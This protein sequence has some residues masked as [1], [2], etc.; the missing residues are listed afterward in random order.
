MYPVTNDVK[1]LF[2][3]EQPQVLRITGV[4]KNGAQILITDANALMGS[5]YIDRFSS[6]N[7]RIEV[8]TA[9]SAEMGVK[10]NNVD[11]TYDNIVFEGAEL[12]VEIGVKDNGSIE[13]QDWTTGDGDTIVT[14]HGQTVGF[15][16]EGT[17]KWVPCGYFICDVQPR[18]Q[19]IITLSALDRMMYFDKGAGDNALV[20]PCTV[21]SLVQQCCVICNVPLV[22]D[23]TVLPNASYNI[24][25]MPQTD[26]MPTYRTLLQWAAQMM[27]VN[28]FIDWNGRLTL[29]W[30]TS[31]DYNTTLDRRFF[32]DLYENDITITGITFK[33]P[34]NDILYVAGTETYALD[35]SGNPLLRME[36]VQVVLSNI[37]TSLVAFVYRPFEATVVPA[38]WL[39]PMD[40]MTFVDAEGVGHISFLTNVNLGL[41]KPTTLMSKGETAQTNRY[42]GGSGLTPEMERAVQRLGR[43]F[44]TSEDMAD[45]I[46]NATEQII[47]ADGGYLRFMY[48]AN[49]VLTELVIMDTDDIQTATKVWR[50]NQGGFGFS[51][52]GYAGPYTTAITQDGQIVANFITAGYMSANR[53]SG[54]TIDG[55][56][57]NAK[58]LNIVDGSGNTIAS[59]NNV[60]TIGKTTDVHAEFDF[61]SLEM[62]DNGGNLFLSLGDA[63]GTGGY[64]DIVETFRGDGTTDAFT[65]NST[66]TSVTSVKINDTTTSNYTR[67]GQTFT[68]TTAPSDGNV[69]EITYNTNQATYHYDLGVRRSGNPVGNYSVV[70]GNLN[71]ATGYCSHA[72]GLVSSAIGESAHAEGDHTYANASSSHAEGRASIASYEASHAEGFH[73]RA[74][75][76]ASHSEGF[77][78]FADGFTSH[79]EGY[80]THA[81]E[82]ASH[83]EGFETVAS[84]HGSH[85]EGGATIAGSTYQHV[86]GEANVPDYNDVYIEIVGNSTLPNRSNARTLDTA[87]NEWIAGTLTQAS[88]ARLKIECGDVPD[89]SGIPARRFR[90]NEKKNRH[91]EK[92]H[93]GYFAQ[94]VEAIAP[95]LVDEDAMGY[96]SLDYV[97]FL[98]AKIASLEKRVAALEAL[99]EKR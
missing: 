47:G 46:D 24:S 50:F 61:N 62:Y 48:D 96:K 19:R 28:A 68:F 38:P 79:A 98:V 97:G 95:Y 15:R 6:T 39:F 78:T 8:G 36:D 60:I 2:E 22:T 29:Q 86:F 57:V 55:G 35:I 70:E 25:A 58:L 14:E 1:A 44:V 99:N 7:T 41:N 75:D 85:A 18:T 81:N 17:T 10:L 83:A 90:W 42:V 73:T 11:G 26:G 53:I 74:R 67:S 80:K 9:V 21:A 93:L 51:S 94:D 40:R 45:A 32:S 72:E 34:K 87:G 64:A 65:V 82:W 43:N 92:E 30:Y 89:V 23:V 5:F 52:N 88:D 12:F 31:A 63:R 56:T 3:A 71:A 69:I 54:G 37:Y 4:D 84:G 33:D 16:L 77:E 91:D 76:Q 49:G 27:G 13:L 20:F 59:F 66:V